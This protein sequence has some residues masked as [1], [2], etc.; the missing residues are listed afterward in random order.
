M[1]SEF[2]II[3][4]TD[5]DG[6]NVIHLDK[7][8]YNRSMR[9][10]VLRVGKPIDNNCMFANYEIDFSAVD[11]PHKLR[12]VLAKMSIT[13]AQFNELYSMDKDVLKVKLINFYESTIKFICD[14]KNS[15]FN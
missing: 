14:S 2:E 13:D 10:S 12:H 9:T 15:I 5:Y 1:E 3:L 11:S 8:W 7:S 4:T 6:N